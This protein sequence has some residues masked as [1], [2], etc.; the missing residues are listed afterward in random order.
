MRNFNHQTYTAFI[1]LKDNT[2]AIPKAILVIKR[3]PMLTMNKFFPGIP[4]ME[5]LNAST[6]YVA[7][8]MLVR[9]DSHNG[10]L[11]NGNNAPLRK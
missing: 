4:S 9:I 8:L 5:F 10:I 6:A 1:L 7:G 2:P 3:T 11:S